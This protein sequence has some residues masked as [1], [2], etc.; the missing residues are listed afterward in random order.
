MFP[1]LVAMAMSPSSSP[2]A[3]L[4]S[5]VI[6]MVPMRLRI[7][8]L[9][10][11]SLAIFC[12]CPMAAFSAL[13]SAILISMARLSLLRLLVIVAS[14][15]NDRLLSALSIERLVECQVLERLL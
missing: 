11:V 14:V 6:F 8:R 9:P 15:L 10:V 4:A 7:S 5:A 2:S 12:I 1:R 13:P 3:Y